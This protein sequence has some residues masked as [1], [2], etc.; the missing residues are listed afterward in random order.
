MNRAL[1]IAAAVL[2]LGGCPN[3]FLSPY[4]PVLDKGIMEFREQFNAF[5][6]SAGELAGKPDGTYE[7]SIKTYAAL[8]AKID[9]LIGRAASGAEG[10]GCKLD[11]KLYEKIERI[12]QTDMPPDLRPEGQKKEGSAAGCNEKLLVLVKAQL[13]RVR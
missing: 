4:D 10:K 6:A 2:L 7:A 9:A 1:L 5:V 8:D 12:V 13:P 3:F 11:R